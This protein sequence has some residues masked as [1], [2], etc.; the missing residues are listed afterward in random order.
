MN[1]QRRIPAY[2]IEG[3]GFLDPYH[4]ALF[5]RLYVARVPHVFETQAN[6]VTI[7]IMVGRTQCQNVQLAVHAYRS[8]TDGCTTSLG[9]R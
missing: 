9:V 5:V 1:K 6:T 8:A 4:Y 7:A 3:H 2:L